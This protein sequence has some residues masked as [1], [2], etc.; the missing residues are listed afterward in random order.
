MWRMVPMEDDKA[1]VLWKVDLC[2][3]PLDIEEIVD[4]RLRLLVKEWWTVYLEFTLVMVRDG[5]VRIEHDRLVATWRSLA[6]DVGGPWLWVVVRAFGFALCL[7]DA[8]E[9]VLSGSWCS[10]GL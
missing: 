8:L 3:M 6:E 9:E 2:D 5:G 4:E 10:F 7:V 1:W